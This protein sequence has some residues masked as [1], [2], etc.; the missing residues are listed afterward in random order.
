MGPK[1]GL[2]VNFKAKNGHYI[3]SRSAFLFLEVP[4]T[5]QSY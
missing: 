4:T 2:Q 3:C 5:V 1:N